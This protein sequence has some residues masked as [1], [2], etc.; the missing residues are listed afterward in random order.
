MGRER[1]G[2]RDGYHT[3]RIPPMLSIDPSK[4]AL[5][6]MHFQNDNVDPKGKFGAQI[7]PFVFENAQRVMAAARRSGLPV[8]HVRVA[9]A[10]G[11]PEIRESPTPL[12]QMVMASGALVDGSWGADF[13]PAVTPADGDL[14]VT[15]R[16]M[17][18]L[19]GTDL[20][21]VLPARGI[22][23]LVLA[24]VS[25]NMIITGTVWE[26]A[27]DQY[28]TVVLGDCCAAGGEDVHAVALN[29][30][31][32]LAMVSTADEFIEALEVTTTGEVKGGDAI[33]R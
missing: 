33:V 1:F 4:S 32:L 21:T 30:L 18:A 15:Q 11:Y 9:F 23:T 16:G 7:P 22:T 2:I 6:L 26:A 3:R 31:S 10:E 8:I 17:S 27:H 19:D 25:T 5:L 20:G 24:G 14:I 28:A 13:H 12:L 29:L